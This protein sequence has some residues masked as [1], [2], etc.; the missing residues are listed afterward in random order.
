MWRRDNTVFPV[1]Y[2]SHP[3]YDRGEIVG[4]VVTFLDISAQKQMQ[5]DKQRLEER[6]RQAQK[7]EAIGTLAGGIAHDFNNILGAIMGHAELIDLFESPDSSDLKASVN[8]IISSSY[9]ARDLIQQILAFSRRSEEVKVPLRLES[10]VKETLQLLRASLPKTIDIRQDIAI[11]PGTLLAD[12]TQIHQVLMNLCTNAAHAMSASGG[13]LKVM[14]APAA[15]SQRIYLPPDGPP[16]IHLAQL[17]IGDNGTG[18]AADVIPRIFEPYFTTKE[19]G[20]GTG[21]GLALAHGII[22]SLGGSIRVASE[23]NRGTVFTMVLPLQDQTEIA[24]QAL[25]TALQKG[26]GRI[27]IVDDERSLVEVG[28]LILKKL[29]YKVV[30]RTDSREAYELVAKVPETFD[31]VITDQTMPQMTGLELSRKLL[32]IR[33]DLPIVLCTGFSDVV[34]EAG[35]KA[36]G[37]A[38]FML[39]P[40]GAK[41]LV[42]VV[43]RLI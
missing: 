35:A 18:I 19:A 25:P 29:G 11:L 10:I 28:S 13:V 42:E 17:S 33:P 15:E 38:A 39:K 20:Q 43:Q 32:R 40:L 7:M 8:E 3:L 26:A 16:A 6:L 1:T 21:L 30:T 12:P 14:V 4:S 36:A 24:S 5:V 9:R 23:L 22:Q 31:L 37:I 41:Q 2:R 34:N 27:L